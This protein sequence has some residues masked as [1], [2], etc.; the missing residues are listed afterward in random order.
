[1]IDI[2]A[3]FVKVVDYFYIALRAG[4]IERCSALDLFFLNVHFQLFNQILN[5]RQIR[6]LD[7]IEKRSHFLGVLRFPVRSKAIEKLAHLEIPIQASLMHTFNLSPLPIIQKRRILNLRPL[8]QQFFNQLMI[9]IA[10]SLEQRIRNLL[11]VDPPLYGLHL[12]LRQDVDVVR[13][14]Q[15]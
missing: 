7:C 13:V 10:D 1:M 5:D 11:L 15:F 2:A 12:L 9:P 8:L 4:P 6:R 14:L 3:S